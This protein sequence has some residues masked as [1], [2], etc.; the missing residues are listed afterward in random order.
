MDDLRSLGGL[1]YR[2]DRASAETA[3]A[4][5]A[6]AVEGGD[7]DERKATPVDAIVVQE[8]EPKP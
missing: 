1:R 4:Q 8:P 5:L 7:G 2:F 3:A 6:L